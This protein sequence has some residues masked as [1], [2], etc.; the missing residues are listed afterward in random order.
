M[1]RNM[2]VSPETPLGGPAVRAGRGRRSSKFGVAG[3]GGG[4]GGGAAGTGGSVSTAGTARALRAQG[5][6]RGGVRGS[7]TV[8]VEPSSTRLSTVIAPPCA[9]TIERAR[10]S[11]SPSPP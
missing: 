6:G 3:A 9:S 1:L 8:K 11:P 7:R 2:V 4:T 10:Y 5:S